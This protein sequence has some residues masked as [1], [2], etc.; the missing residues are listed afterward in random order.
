MGSNLPPNDYKSNT[1][2][3]SYVQN[4]LVFAYTDNWFYSNVN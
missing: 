2:P 4:L 3:L 1:K